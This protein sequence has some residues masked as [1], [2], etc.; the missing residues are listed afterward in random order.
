MS[1]VTT[2]AAGSEVVERYGLFIDNRREDPAEGDHLDVVDPA[3][4][5]TWAQVPNAS[6]AAVDRAVRSARRAFEDGDWPAY[7]AADRA[8][9]PD[10]L[11][12]DA[13]AEHADELADLQVRE[14]GKL[15]REMGGQAK[16]A[17]QLQLLRG[18]GADADRRTNPLH[19]TDMLNYTVREPIGVV[20]AITPWNSP[21]TAAL[22]KLAPALAAG[23]RGHQAVRGHAG[24]HAGA[25]P[26]SSQRRASRRRRQ[27]RHRAGSRRHAPSSRTRT[28]TRSRSPARRRSGKQIA[29]DRGAGR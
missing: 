27:R 20:A 8:D 19:L 26:S 25:R 4:G 28:S 15:I 9:V 6:E 17:G 3:T 10:P 24:L 11:R 5:R 14:N 22:W 23:T 29:A 2:T 13:I 1:Q 7:R 18:C 21:L 12:P 16:L